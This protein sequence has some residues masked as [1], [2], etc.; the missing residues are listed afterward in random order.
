MRFKAQLGAS[1]VLGVWL[2]LLASRQTALY[3]TVQDPATELIPTMVTLGVI[4]VALVGRLL[5]PSTSVAVVCMAII[6]C[7]AALMAAQLGA[8][9]ANA[10]GDVVGGDYCGDL[11]RTAILGRF[12]WFF[13][14]PLLTA[15]VLVLLGRSD[16]RAVGGLDRVIWTRAWASATLV[17][18]LIGSAVWWRIILPN[19]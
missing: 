8:P 5:A 11:C 19:G 1:S 6:S 15:T 3:P 17:L 16:G 12:L 10:S 4:V 9:L 13:G 18:G 7:G 2:A 14:W